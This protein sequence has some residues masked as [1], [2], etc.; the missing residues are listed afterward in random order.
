MSGFSYPAPFEFDKGPSSSSSQRSKSHKSSEQ[1]RHRSSQPSPSRQRSNS[2]GSSSGISSGNNNG[3]KGHGMESISEKSSLGHKKLAVH[4]GSVGTTV[5]APARSLGPKTKS[6]RVLPKPMPNRPLGQSAP[7]RGRTPPKSRGV[8]HSRSANLEQMRGSGNQRSSSAPRRQPARSPSPEDDT[9]KPSSLRGFLKSP[10][11]RQAPSK[12]QSGNLEDLR[13]SLKKNSIVVPTT[14]EPPRRPKERQAS[15]NTAPT[16]SSSSIGKEPPMRR[17]ESPEHRRPSSRSSLKDFLTSPMRLVTPTRSKSSDLADMVRGSK[18][19]ISSIGPLDLEDD[20]EKSVDLA[21]LGAEKST[22][23]A[24][25]SASSRSSRRRKEKGDHHH[26]GNGDEH[27]TKSFKQLLGGSR[28]RSGESTSKNGGSD[29]D[30]NSAEK[31]RR[32]PEPDAFDRQLSLSPEEPQ[33]RKSVAG[34]SMLTSFLDT[35]YDNYI[36]PSAHQEQEEEDDPRGGGGS[37]MQNSFSRLDMSLSNFL[38]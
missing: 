29:T 6:G 19:G 2:H 1:P 15:T 23:S 37:R 7:K 20:E 35:L 32:S 27:K 36:D 12:T 30:R 21:D 33:A 18:S 3:S 8:G 28:N 13:R 9:P 38:T 22:R 10:L 4:Q 25:T 5:K 31:S 26:G 11:S 14:A 24:R 17:D 16:S 34:T